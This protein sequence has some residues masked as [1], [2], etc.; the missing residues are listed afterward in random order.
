M[1]CS[2]FLR[3][4]YSCENISY[5]QNPFHDIFY[6][7]EKKDHFFLI[8]ICNLDRQDCTQWWKPHNPSRIKCNIPRWSSDLQ[9]ST[10]RWDFC[11][12]TE[13]LF[14]NNTLLDKIYSGKKTFPDTALRKGYRST[15]SLIKYISTLKI[16]GTCS[17]LST[18][19]PVTSALQTEQSV[20]TNNSWETLWHDSRLCQ[21]LCTTSS[22]YQN[23]LCAK[24]DMSALW[25]QWWQLRYV[26]KL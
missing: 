11:I 19:K 10:E 8:W 6:Q 18:P 25:W 24:Q 22:T 5:I 7:G 12:F 13:D 4:K 16:K 26:I 9:N 14:H 17:T 21:G 3:L 23:K 20:G 15:A 2:N 1:F